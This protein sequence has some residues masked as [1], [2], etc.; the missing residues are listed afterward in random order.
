VT[1]IDRLV[2]VD[3]FSGLAQTVEELAEILLHGRSFGLA[4][5]RS[6]KAPDCRRNRDAGGA[7]NLCRRKLLNRRVL[8]YV[9]TVFIVVS[10]VIYYL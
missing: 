8:R 7:R 6:F 2:Q 3:E 4:V 10:S 1:N 5:G 9:R